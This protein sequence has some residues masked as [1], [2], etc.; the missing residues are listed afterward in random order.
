MK[1]RKKSNAKRW[2]VSIVGIAISNITARR[3]PSEKL[4]F[5]ERIAEK[6]YAFDVDLAERKFRYD[7]DLHDHKR[8]G[9]FAEDLLASFYKFRDVIAGVRSPA[10][11]G[12]EGATRQQADNEPPDLARS[13][14]NYFV[15]LERLQ[16]NAD[17][18]SEFF[19]KQYRAKAVFGDDLDQAFRLA[20]G[21]IIAIRVSAAYL[22][23]RVGEVR[24]FDRWEQR[25]ADIWD[26]FG[27]DQDKLTPK[28]QEALKLA[29]QSLGPVLVGA[30]N[31]GLAPRPNAD[32]V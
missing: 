28:I 15:P 6:K 12:D 3:L 19:S 30:Q 4:Q 27:D 20:N 18:L 5:D 26:G 25:E 17:F 16:K 24:D 9:E 23:R 11:F 21:V 32:E 22:I 13:R 2:F 8:R 10:A 7:R 1:H 31:E 14:N 29:E